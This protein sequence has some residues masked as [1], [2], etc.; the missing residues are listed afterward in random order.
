MKNENIYK[1][2]TDKIVAEMEKGIIPWQKPW[3]RVKGCKPME[4]GFG[5]C[6]SHTTGKAYSWLNQMM[7]GLR[8]GEWL[9]FNQCKAEGGC[10]K[11]GEKASTVVF[12]AFLEKTET[13]EKTGEETTKKIPYLKYY[14]VFHIDLCTGIKAKFDKPSEVKPA[15]AVEVED[16]TAE[17][18]TIEAAENIVNGYFS[19]EAC[20]LDVSGSN[21][22]YYMPMFDKVVVPSIK[23]YD[24]TAEYYSTLFHEMTHSTGH[25]SRLNRLEK[26]AAFGSEDYSKEELVAEMGSAMLV[27]TAGIDS[28]KAFRN[29]VGYLQG[30]G[31][32]QIH[33][34]RQTRQQL[35][36]Q[37][38][39]AAN[40]R[41]H[42]IKQQC[43]KQ[44]FVLLTK[45]SLKMIIIS[46][47][48]TR[49]NYY[50]AQQVGFLATFAD[51]LT[52]EKH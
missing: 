1:M 43:I 34:E 3:K 21:E 5:G 17:L 49:A 41:P 44:K 7:L 2:V 42:K 22:A 31:G 4:F 46:A 14:K 37:G 23:Q 29:S 27:A 47:M 36:N 51:C 38:N 6:I 18:D 30:G 28:E 33:T 13:D 15:E 20:T 24:E 52:L 45:T 39:G 8:A 25:A 40:H 9:T 12:W 26:T 19:R 32:C 10:V 48:K 11:A 35:I 16:T 50:F